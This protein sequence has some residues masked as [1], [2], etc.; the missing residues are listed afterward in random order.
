MFKSI[1]QMIQFLFKLSSW[2]IESSQRGSRPV[3]HLGKTSETNKKGSIRNIPGSTRPL[4][5]PHRNS[6]SLIGCWA[7]FVYSR[8]AG[9]GQSVL[10]YSQ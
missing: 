4:I 10:V 9:A 6:W 5:G 7:G 2:N 3:K 1:V 8:A